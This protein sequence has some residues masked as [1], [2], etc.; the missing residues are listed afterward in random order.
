[1][2]INQISTANTFGQLV[3]AVSAM[4]AVSNNFTDGPQVVSNAA[5]TFSNPGVGVNVANTLL[6]QTAN[7]QVLNTSQANVTNE[8]VGRSNISTAN[9]TTANIIGATITNVISTDH[10]SANA[11]ITG[12]LQVSDR[13]NIFSANIQFANIGT[14]AITSLSVAE[15]TV[16]VLNASFANITTLSVTGTSQHN[17]LV[18]TL[19]TTDNCNVRILNVTSANI[20]NSFVATL[21]ASSANITSLTVG[22]QN[23]S[24]ANITT[25]TVPVLN[26][27]FANITNETVGTANISTANITNLFANVANLISANVS[28]VNIFSGVISVTGNP[29]TNL[30]VATKNYVDT[31]AGANLVNK[32]SFN[33]KGDIIVG[34]GANTYAAL[35]TGTNGQVVIVD[36]NQTPG[37]RYSGRVSQ[38][39]RGLVMCTSMSNRGANSNGFG[40]QLTVYGLDEAVMDDGEVV[41]GWT[42]PATIDITS[43]GAVNLLDI[44]SVIAN[45]WYEV[46]A[47]RKRSD[48]LKG[49]ILH[50]AL[51]RRAEQN[52][53]NAIFFPIQ[54]GVAAG[55]GVNS[56]VAFANSKIAQSF[57]PNVAGPLTSIEVRAF[58]TGAPTGNIWLTLHANTAGDPNVTTLA[59]SRRMDAARVPL[60]TP[61]NLRFI[62][63]TTSN[64]ALANSYFW[65]FNSDQGAN[66]TAFVN[67]AYSLANTL[68]NANGVNEGIPKG[69][70]NVSW[71]DLRPGVGTFIYKTYV[72]AN[73]TAVTMPTGYDQ[74]CLISYAA[75]DANSRFKE[76]HQ[77]DRTITAYPTGQWANYTLQIA[78]PEVI[79][80]AQYAT[81]PPVPCIVS[82]IA[83][84]SS[85]N[86]YG[87]G[88]LYALDT[89]SVA[90]IATDIISGAFIAQINF[91]TTASCSP[92]VWIEHQAILIK[93]GLAAFKLFPVSIT[94]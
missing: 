9:V 72:E 65:V 25:L 58:R 79:D 60:T 57:T 14:V 13:A 48:G 31:G 32:L 23:I 85:L 59:S 56:T 18:A 42:L 2:S 78:N 77:K 50:R 71:A 61:A 62:F 92:P 46:Y 90:V 7:V 20:S 15:L 19:V 16:P 74:K 80:F 4:I 26:A 53:T 28:T 89:P 35:N 29:T 76:Y 10:L 45:T 73:S 64:V 47:I 93:S 68:L 63:D 75:T 69:F 83:V 84:G 6:V 12:L 44:G 1:M 87:I 39:F 81:I 11:N 52:T 86:T 43:S 66:A 8:T 36:T 40:S 34:T 22:T 55:L 17:A 5:W 49:F 3:T 94:F 54:A 41:T 27:S 88:R 70:N 24:S 30:Q 91:S 51:D 67:V 33:A 37:V 21:N 38:V 82:F